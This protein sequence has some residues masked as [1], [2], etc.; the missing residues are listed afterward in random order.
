MLK[1]I[2]KPITIYNKTAK[3]TPSNIE[4]PLNI[5]SG[6]AFCHATRSK[7]LVNFLS[8]LN[9]SASYQKVI[10][11][12]KNIAQSVLKRRAENDNVF[13]PLNISVD[14]PITFAIDN[15]DLKIH[16]MENIS[17]MEQLLW[18]IRKNLKMSKYNINI[19]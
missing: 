12:K 8:D 16:L 11:I 4:T 17:C 10:G 14:R 18:F 2:G 6:I 1:R 5:G 19:F 9:V 7:K 13:I 3:T 15:I